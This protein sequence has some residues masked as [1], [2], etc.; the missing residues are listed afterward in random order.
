MLQVPTSVQVRRTQKQVVALPALT[1]P[2]SPHLI[3]KPHESPSFQQDLNESRVT[4]AFYTWSKQA[5][6]VLLRVAQ[7]QGHQ[8]NASTCAH[9][10]KI[11]FQDIRYFPAV[12]GEQATT[13]TDR[14][15]HKALCRVLEV[16]KARAGYR[17]STTWANTPEVLPHLHEP[18]RQ[19]PAE[20]LQGLDRPQTATAAQ[21]VLERAIEQQ[22]QL[23]RAQRLSS[24]KRSMR[25]SVSDQSQWFA[26]RRRRQVLPVAADSGQ[27]TASLS[28]RAKIIRE[29]WSKIYSAHQ[30][31]EPSLR[32][33]L[34]KYG[35]TLKRA[36]VDLPTLDGEMLRRKIK[37]TKVSSPGMDKWGIEELKAI[38]AWAPSLFDWLARLLRVVEDKGTW[39]DPLTH[40]AVCFVPK[41]LDG[42]IPT[43]MQHCPITILSSV[44]RLWAAIR[45]DQLAQHWQPLWAPHGAYGLNGRPAADSLVFD[46]CAFLA[47]ATHR[48]LMVGGLSYDL[49]K[50]FDRVPVS[51][52]VHILR[53]RGCDNKI[54]A[55]LDGFYAQ[56]VKH[57]RIQGH[58]DSPFYPSNG[59]V[60]GCPLSMLV[61]SSLTAAWLEH[62]QEH[63]PEVEAK[64]Y[65]DDLSLCATAARPRALRAKVAA[66]HSHTHQFVTRSG[67]KLNCVKSF[68]FGHQSLH[69]CIPPLPNHKRSFRLTGGTVKLDAKP[70][71]TQLEK[72]KAAKWTSS[73]A[74]IRRVP[75][76]WFTKVKWLQRVSPQLT[77]RV[78]TQTR[79]N[80]GRRQDAEGS[81]RP[82]TT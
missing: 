54:C 67:L 45:H 82:C 68:S 66:V 22:Y 76:G 62:L 29:A 3:L 24:W 2:D 58:Y 7:Q 36:V 25:S 28:G 1:P 65:A 5:E 17:R 81:G 14:K 46:T 80:S 38:A 44:Y 39:P 71:W 34:D 31:G 18:Y 30:H 32:S 16:Q 37:D 70:C 53:A 77:C 72:L 9:R 63:E 50:C 61:L 73:V 10:G 15:L 12:R 52:A 55:A 60:Q 56:H 74:S 51:L 64:S 48:G 26:K 59:L 78:H 13:M 33:F 40:G 41:E 43:A 57:F 4:E 6:Q 27:T 11:K 8:V 35:P 42:E 75:V 23:K 79:F 21:V 69:G 20:L 49:E 47:Q 19:Q